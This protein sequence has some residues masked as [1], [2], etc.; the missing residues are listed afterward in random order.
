MAH[1]VW[2]EFPSSLVKD[3]DDVDIKLFSSLVTAPAQ[4]NPDKSPPCNQAMPCPMTSSH[5]LSPRQ[6]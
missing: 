6:C 4:V 3:G 5:L 1:E 2:G